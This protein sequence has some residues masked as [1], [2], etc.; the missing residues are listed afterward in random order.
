MGDVF[1]LRAI[2]GVGE[3]TALDIHTYFQS[4]SA[5]LMIDRLEAL[6][7]RCIGART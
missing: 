3:K 1:R 5:V 2:P 7:I 4:S 6:G